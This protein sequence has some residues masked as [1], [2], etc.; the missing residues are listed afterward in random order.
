M[1]AA[2]N[3]NR[4]I[5]LGFT[6][7]FHAL[8]FLLFILIVFITPIP[9]FVQPPVIETDVIIEDG[10][11]NGMGRNA[12]GSGNH[13]NDMT[14]SP[15]AGA[16]TPT[17]TATAAN[18]V[19][20]PDHVTDETATDASVNKSPVPKTNTSEEAKTP[21]EEQASRDL[22]EALARLKNK[23]QHTGEGEGSGQTGGSGN[24]SSTGAGNGNNPSGGNGTDPNGQPGTGGWYLVGR[25]LLTKPEKLTDAT[26]EGIVVVDITVDENGKVIDAKAGAR[27]STT[28]SQKLYSKAQLAAKQLKFNPSPDG[29]KEQHGTYKV[30]FTLE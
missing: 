6:L 27:G 22:L 21:A 25:T 1:E 19:S 10:G 13:D 12:G 23:H 17:H 28:F 4:F 5:A 20:A 30:I 26:D 15:E 14:T 2:E 9:P 24:G 29:K 7:G 3:K 8:L 16:S 11:S 18:N